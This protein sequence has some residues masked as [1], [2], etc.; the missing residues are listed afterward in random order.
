MAEMIQLGD[1]VIAMTRKDIKHVHLSVHPPQGRV[2]LVAPADTRPE[3]A[4][5][6]AISKIDWIRDQR[7]K[8]RRQARHEFIERESHYL[9][10]RQHL[11][12]VLEDN[13]K[14]HV[15]ANHRTLTPVVRPGSDTAKRE[16]VVHG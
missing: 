5:A 3:V 7:A 1:I 16:A 14:P 12:T 10:G 6:Y 15:L 13:V 4:R 8:M 11:L 2:S 9:W